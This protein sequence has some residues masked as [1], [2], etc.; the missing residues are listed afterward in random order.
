MLLFPLADQIMCIFLNSRA[1]GQFPLL[2][3]FKGF[4][5]LN[6]TPLEIYFQ[7]EKKLPYL[8]ESELR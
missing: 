3:Y 7:L 2:W 1:E 6:S 8:T 4:E 5:R